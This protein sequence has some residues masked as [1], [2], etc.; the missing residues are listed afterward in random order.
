MKSIAFLNRT[1]SE[2]GWKSSGRT[3]R[4]GPAEMLRRAGP[5][6]PNFISIRI[7]ERFFKENSN[8]IIN[9]FQIEHWSFKKMAEYWRNLRGILTKNGPSRLKFGPDRPDFSSLRFTTLV[10]RLRF[11]FFREAS[12]YFMNQ[13]LKIS[14]DYYSNDDT[15]WS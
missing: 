15:S 9:S 8:L 10:L 6:M 2:H 7:L 11:K 13:K 12:I 4:P 5:V 14:Q 1:G 3:V